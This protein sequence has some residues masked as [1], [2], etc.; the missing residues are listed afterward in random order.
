M[1]SRCGTCLLVG[2]GFLS[3]GCAEMTSMRAPGRELTKTPSTD[4]RAPNKSEQPA[5]LRITD[6]PGAT[7]VASENKPNS[8]ALTARQEP[9][10]PPA[11]VPPLPVQ[12]SVQPANSAATQGAQESGADPRTVFRDLYG[13]AARR[14]AG[15]DSY[16]LRLRRREMVGDQ[17]MPEELMILKYRQQPMSVYLKWLGPEGKGREVVY[18]QGRY[19]NKLQVR[20]A[21]GDIIFMPA[22]KRM[23]FAPDNPLVTA[24]SR[25]PI[26]EAGLGPLIARFG[27][28]VEA[29]DKGDKSQ[30]S[31][32]YLGPMQRP[33]FEHKLETVQQILPRKIDPLFPRGGLRLWFFDPE[34][35]MP[36]LVISQD[37]TG[38]E[39]EYYCHDRIQFSVGLD[40]DDFN[41]DLLW[42]GGS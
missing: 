15:I 35:Q 6:P 26:T 5:S 39:V 7:P 14:Y 24:K 21:A 18:V 10:A 40:N 37:D 33:E 19:D 27:R 3:L 2:A 4:A 29:L 42:K 12:P 36:L 28:L 13:K 30:G 1:V 8:F 9:E 41:P 32:K 38:R 34:T 17:R 20:L 23:A 16:V 11:P 25:Y 22:G 31:A